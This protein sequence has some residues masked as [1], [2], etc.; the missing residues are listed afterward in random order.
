MAPT[1]AIP[2]TTPT[3]QPNIDFS[4]FG[5][6]SDSA[7]QAIQSGASLQDVQNAYN[8]TQ[9]QAQPQQPQQKQP[10]W[11]EKL[12]PT[13]G[14]AIGGI[15]G[16][17]VPIP[18]LDVA[19]GIGGA[20]AGG[21]I[22]QKIENMLT[23][24][25]QSTLAAGAENALGQGAGMGLGF[26]GKGVANAVGGAFGK[27]A[28]A[29]V[30]GQ[31]KG[32]ISPELANDLRI[33][34]GI[35][36]LAGEGQKIANVVTGSSDSGE[37]QALIN[38]A[39]ENGI[40]KNGPQRVDL[41]DLTTRP[42]TGKT[43]QVASGQA[44]SSGNMA[45]QFMTQ[46]ALTETQKQAVRSN[47]AA[48][49]DAQGKTIAG[50][51]DGPGALSFNRRV[52]A[53]ADQQRQTYLNSGMQDQTAKNL[54]NAYQDIQSEV[55]DR[56][57]SPAGQGIAIP[58]TEKDILTKD[59]QT[60]V[61]Q[62]NPKAATAISNDVQNAKTYSDLRSVQAKWVT[63][64]RGVQTN[65]QKAAQNYGVTSGDL[66]RAGL[67]VVGAMAGGGKGAIVGAGL[68]AA[69]KLGSTE[70]L[71]AKG[72]SKLAG[73]LSKGT[74]DQPAS[75]LKSLGITNKNAG[76]VNKIIPL[77]TRA[78]ALGTA[79][80]P[81]IAG[82]SQP[83]GQITQGAGMQGT[84]GAQGAGGAGAPGQDALSQ[85]YNTLYQQEQLGFGGTQTGS[86]ISALN[87]L[88]P[89]VNKQ[90]IAANAIQQL[91]PAYQNAGGAQGLGGGLEQYATGLIPGTAANVYGKQQQATAGALGGALGIS[92]AQ[93]GGLTP[94]LMSNQQTANPQI[95][96]LQNLLSLYG[97]QAAPVAQ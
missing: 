49:S 12:L 39:V 9:Q 10:S 87:Q 56:L 57:F 34:H 77:G 85:L 20:A 74:N 45:E 44:Q 19:T 28:D 38:K 69:S 78:L 50:A 8:K 48:I 14:G 54:M 13:A 59:I 90:Q 75:V 83:T 81:N 94:Q 82:A 67:P 65:V 22:G 70:A 5:N 16:G 41:S 95:T 15:L 29:L 80:S 25:K 64:N 33:N 51:T 17:L 66:I 1:S 31:A 2:Q 11:W 58:Q 21:A 42:L 47:I 4:Q 37:G 3:T 93:A 76:L 60:H 35:T 68:G 6:Y 72:F 30:A 71:G 53:L 97:G 92:P 55:N 52:G 43:A 18:G 27:G 61:G 96:A 91:M 24:Q 88:A 86:L 7:R 84:Q 32:F 23:G 26:L 46:H 40:F 79:N 73:T 62:I 89:Q 36:N 63:V